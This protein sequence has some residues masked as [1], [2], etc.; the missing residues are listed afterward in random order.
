MFRELISKEICMTK[1]LGLHG[2]LFGGIMLSYI[3]KAGAIYACEQCTS[4]SLV[5]LSM[6]KVLF[7]KPVKVGDVLYFYGEVTKFGNSSIKIKVE[8]FRKNI[9]IV[10]LELVCETSIVFVQIDKDGN[11]CVIESPNKKAFNE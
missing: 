5:T 1:D 6:D 8:V 7:R 2:N 11:S 3:D 9:S 4:D 10:D